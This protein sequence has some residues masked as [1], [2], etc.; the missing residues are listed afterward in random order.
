MR[1]NDQQIQQILH[2]MQ[3]SGDS[4]IMQNI[5][6]EVLNRGTFIN[7]G[8]NPMMA[9]TFKYAG[10]CALVMQ[11][12]EASEGVDPRFNN[13]SFYLVSIDGE[14]DPYDSDQQELLAPL[15]KS[16]A[17]AGQNDNSYSEE[18]T[19]PSGNSAPSEYQYP[20]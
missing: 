13:H 18:W 20:S 7:P 19:W 12:T 14:H 17:N 2:N 16:L 8:P 3:I 6:R 4:K 5:V 10:V 1:F 15:R 11:K 9:Y